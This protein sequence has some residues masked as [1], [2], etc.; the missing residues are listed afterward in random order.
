MSVQLKK[1]RK[2][3]SLAAPLCE[4]ADEK[5]AKCPIPRPRPGMLNSKALLRCDDL[6]PSAMAQIT[7]VVYFG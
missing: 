6:L 7:E 4:P 3:V 2:T 1:Q 5:Q